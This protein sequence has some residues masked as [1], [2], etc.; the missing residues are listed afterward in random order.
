MRMHEAGA[1]YG[2]IAR[3]LGLD[4]HHVRGA[5]YLLSRCRPI[6]SPERL[7]LVA[8]RDQGLDDEDIAEMWG[9]TVG[10]ARTVRKYAD[11]I[12]E[13]EPIK[14]YLEEMRGWHDPTDPSPHQIWQVECKAFLEAKPR[15]KVGEGVFA[16]QVLYDGR[17]ETFIPIG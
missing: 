14:Q 6:P 13:Q 4:P 15:E 5:I 2:L 12:R 17:N 1:S 10:W 8:M 3:T 11:Q 16:M 7:A 9:R